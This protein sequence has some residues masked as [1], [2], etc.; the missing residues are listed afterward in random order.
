MNIRSDLARVIWETSR[1]DEGTISVTGANHVA[2]EV[3]RRWLPFLAE[4][5]A[6]T[7]PVDGAVVRAYFGA[8]LDGLAE[9]RY[10]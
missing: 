1:E 6:R 5:L 10:G 8:L 7:V 2:D 9:G 4:D 3:L